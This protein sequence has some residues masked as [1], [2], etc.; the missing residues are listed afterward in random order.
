[1]HL[2][3]KLSHISLGNE[4]SRSYRPRRGHLHS[5]LFI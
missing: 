2:R 4:P 1:L 5:H 3:I